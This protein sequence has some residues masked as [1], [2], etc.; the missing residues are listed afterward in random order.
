MYYIDFLVNPFTVDV[1]NDGYPIAEYLVTESFAMEM[2]LIKLQENRA[3]KMT[4]KYEPIID[5]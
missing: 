1:T 3:M 2:E 4:G 5:F